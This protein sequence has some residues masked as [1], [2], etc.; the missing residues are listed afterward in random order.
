MGDYHDL[1][2][3]TDNLLLADM[4]QKFINTFLDYYGLDA[5]HY[6]SSPGLS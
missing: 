3:K 5:C 1:D 6:F 2:L 4:F